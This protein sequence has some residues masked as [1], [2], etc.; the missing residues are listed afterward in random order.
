MSEASGAYRPTL[1]TIDLAAIE[2]NTRLCLKELAGARLCA[3]VKADAYGHGLVPAARAAL[4]GGAGW[5]GVATLEEGEA[6]R[7][8]GISAPVLVMAG[9]AGVGDADAEAGAGLVR[10]AAIRCAVRRELTLAIYDPRTLMRL[11]KTARRLE[12]RVSAH[13]KL[14]TGM[15][16]VGVRGEALENLLDAWQDAP[17]VEMQGAFSHFACADEDGDFTRCQFE[18]FG[19]ALELVRA[20]G[21][22]PMRHIAASAAALR[23]PETRLDMARIGI[24]LYGAGVNRWLPELRPAQRLTTRP[25]MLKWIEPGRSVSYGAEFTATRATRVMTLPIGYGD[26]YRRAIGGRGC[27]LVGGARAPVIGRVCMD[28]LMLDVTDIPG[29]DMDSEV[30]L[31]GSQGRECITPDEMAQW[32]GTIAYEIMLGFSARVRRVW[33]GG[34]EG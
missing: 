32:A 9:V 5:L 19:R 12:T 22:A 14:D 21:L 33:V 1:L 11:E 25:S 3:A 28:Q 23:F 2:A 30:V 24:A 8:A 26:G 29:A 27:A 6:L 7:D 10:S 16:R 13:L 4:R 20:R 31:L 15:S 18:E 34:D 17:H